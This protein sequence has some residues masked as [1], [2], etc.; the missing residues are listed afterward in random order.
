MCV[1]TMDVY[2][3]V[4]RRIVPYKTHRCGYATQVM[5]FEK[6]GQMQSQNVQWDRKTHVICKPLSDVFVK[7]PPPSLVARSIAGYT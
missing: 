1:S 6:N 2:E 4:C 3:H 7:R 5:H